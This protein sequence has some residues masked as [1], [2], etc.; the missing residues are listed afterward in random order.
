MD[1]EIWESTKLADNM[2]TQEV[3]EA[4]EKEKRKTRKKEPL[5]TIFRCILFPNFS[6]L[7][8]TCNLHAV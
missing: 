5:R 2:N 1:N 4:T 8:D 3:I 7:S 6:S